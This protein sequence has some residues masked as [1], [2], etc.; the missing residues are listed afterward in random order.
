MI[1]NATVQHRLK[2]FDQLLAEEVAFLQRSCEQNLITYEKFEKSIRRDCDQ[3]KHLKRQT[4]LRTPTIDDDSIVSIEHA[5]SSIISTTHIRS[6]S[7]IDDKLPTIVPK[8]HRHCY[9]ARRLPPIVKFSRDK[10]TKTDYPWSRNRSS[11]NNENQ[12]F[13]LLEDKLPNVPPSGPTLIEERVQ[14]FIDTL[15]PNKGLQKGFDNFAAAALYS[16]RT[17]VLMK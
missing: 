14:S 3:I 11:L 6:P 2:H 4:F 15:P 8:F 10:R 5:P 9:K 17:P 7:L 13:M 12:P 16:R 1:P